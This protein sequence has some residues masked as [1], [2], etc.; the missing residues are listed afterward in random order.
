MMKY[1]GHIYR[2]KKQFWPPMDKNKDSTFKEVEASQVIQIHLV[3]IIG[4]FTS[5]ALFL[6]EKV[7]N[8]WKF[9]KYLEN[10]YFV[11]KFDDFN[12]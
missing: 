12:H 9:E 2:L 7:Y 1:K 3:L 6:C 10:F 8:K 4:I 11:K 5:S